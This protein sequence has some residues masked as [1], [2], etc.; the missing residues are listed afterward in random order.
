MA[1]IKESALIAGVRGSV[2]GNTFSS[3][4]YGAYARQKVSPTQPQTQRQ[5]QQRI[6]LTTWS[7]AWRNLEDGDRAAWQAWAQNH[8]IMDVFGNAQ[9]LAGNAAFVKVQAFIA[10]IGLDALTAPPA[11]PT[12]VQPAA[13]SIGMVPSTGILTVTLAAAC[14]ALDIYAVFSTQGFSPGRAFASSAF[15]YAGQPTPVTP[16]ATI[17]LTPTD[18][19]PLLVVAAGQKV[20]AVVVRCTVQGLIIDKTQLSCIAAE[21]GP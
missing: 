20:G 12:T 7:Q 13:A 4:R 17:T 16:F 8:P 14:T 1:R 18:V 9:I 5:N 11:D 19:N 10:T 2:A 21:V 15:R 3:G 6:I